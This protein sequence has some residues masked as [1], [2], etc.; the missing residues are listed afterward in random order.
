M[1]QDTI[2]SD[3]SSVDSAFFASAP[4]P[5]LR[6]DCD[7]RSSTD[8][9]RSSSDT[10]MQSFVPFPGSVESAYT[11]RQDVCPDSR[12]DPRHTTFKADTRPDMRQDSRQWDRQRQ[13]SSSDRLRRSVPDRPPSA[14]PRRLDDEFFQEIERAQQHLQSL[15]AQFS[16][17][18]TRQT[19][20]SRHSANMASDAAVQI[21]AHPH[22]EAA[23]TATIHS[24]DDS[25]DPEEYPSDYFGH[26]HPH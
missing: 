21:S 8:S 6:P 18:R 16:R 4:P 24:D 14:P 15:V 22:P 7:L 13:D 12:P 10:A 9:R 1:Y 23:Y 3:E 26:V 20:P 19:H 2:P 5:I 11:A 17:D 25:D